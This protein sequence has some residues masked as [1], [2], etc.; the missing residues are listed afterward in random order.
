[1]RNL[2]NVHRRRR[3]RKGFDVSTTWIVKLKSTAVDW[4]ARIINNNIVC[5]RRNLCVSDVRSATVNFYAGA[6]VS[7]AVS[8]YFKTFSR[9][10]KWERER[11]SIE[12]LS[13]TAPAKITATKADSDADEAWPELPYTHTCKMRFRIP[14]RRIQASV[15]ICEPERANTFKLILKILRWAPQ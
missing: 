15:C 8:A 14:F 9:R 1:M 2:G 6:P 7:C 11:E 3:R 13:N 12:I 10:R 5:M 4:N